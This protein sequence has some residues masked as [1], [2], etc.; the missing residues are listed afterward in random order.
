MEQQ[1]RIRIDKNNVI[2]EVDN[3][4]YGSFI[5]HVGRA[6]YSGIYQP[7]HPAADSQGFR[8]DVLEYVRELTVSVT[9]YP[10]GNFVSG[11]NWEDG[12]GPKEHRPKRLDPAWFALE[13][14]K[15]GLNEFCDWAKAAGTEVMMAINLGTR[16]AADAKNIIEYCNHPS[17]SLLSDLRIRHG[18]LEPH[19]I[20]LWCLGNEMDGSWQIGAK[21]ASE[22]GRLAN[23]AS[24]IMKAIDYTIETVACG[25]SYEDMKTFGSWEDTVLSECYDNVDYISLHSYYDN[26]GGETQ[27]FLAGGLQMDRY[28]KRVAGICDGVQA[29]LGS[30]K[31]INL[32][33]DEWNVWYHSK[34]EDWSC[35]RWVKAHKRLE[36]IYNVGD[37]VLVGSLLITLINNCDRVKIGCMAQLVNAIAPIMTSEKGYA[38]RQTIFY[39]FMHA[40]RYGRGTAIRPEIESPKF[41]CEKFSD[42]PHI[43][44]TCVFDENESVLSMFFV[45]RNIEDDVTAYIDLAGFGAF[46]VLEEL[47]YS[48]GDIKAVNSSDERT[49]T[50][51][52]PL[53]ETAVTKGII[54]IRLPRVSWN[55]LR[56]KVG[57]EEDLKPEIPAEPKP[58]P[59]SQIE[60]R[61]ELS[62][63]DIDKELRVED[64]E[65]NIT[66]D[67]LD[68][69][70]SEKLELGDLEGMF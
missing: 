50:L 31:R 2:S 7:G 17:G 69:G 4:L 41:S 5:E 36:D 62:F 11:Y 32:S 66:G 3:R 45:N 60:E 8:R 35:P 16:G 43:D 63:E 34:E 37:A 53:N 14:N 9:R 6:V 68:D 44:G 51:P 55:V 15:F 22:Y 67:D 26:S 30:S 40:S 10:G 25:S 23:E 64:A 47:R 70:D 56:V 28:I 46:Q 61:K 19:N 21:T 54:T 12:I 59:E 57:I 42:V 24:K 13:D 33:F 65:N 27:S 1:A 29:R 52:E 18:Y 49:N 38:W 39:P 58:K 48:N 20:K